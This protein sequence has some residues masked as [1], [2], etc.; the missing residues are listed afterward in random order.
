MMLVITGAHSVTS[1]SYWFAMQAAVL[2]YGASLARTPDYWLKP[3]ELV[4][5]AADEAANRTIGAHR[6]P[7]PNG[8]HTH[9]G[10]TELHDTL[11][12]T[13]RVSNPSRSQLVLHTVTSVSTFVMTL[14][15]TCMLRL[16]QTDL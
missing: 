4:S 16:L 8:R 6:Q 13:T 12:S 10:S 14:A 9:D 5:S 11:R 1:K 3:L 15:P 7:S 2:G